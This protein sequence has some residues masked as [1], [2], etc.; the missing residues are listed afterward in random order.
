MG[1]FVEGLKTGIY[2]TFILDN[3]YQYFIRGLGVTLLVTIFA[4]LIGIVLGVIVAIIRSA[5]DQQTEKKKGI[6]LKLANGICQIYLTVIRG[7][8]ML[9][10]L[11]IMWFVI[12]ASAR[13]TDG[14]MIR[15]A[16]LSFGINSGAYIAEIVRSGIMSI[17]KGQMEAGRSVGLTYATTMRCIIIPQAFKNVL[18]ALGNEL[19]TLVKE[20]SVVTVIG[21]KDLTKGA[22]IIQS[23]TYQ[24]LVPFFAIA[25]IYLVIVLFLSWLMGKLERRMRKSDLR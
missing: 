22:M 10:Q 14:N 7:T 2:Q 1:N 11:L 17:D 8:P 25:A 24:A 16:I 23:K 3:N 13:A 4:L 19:I 12:W 6:V 5:Y 9:V 20:T 21:L 15:C 18:P